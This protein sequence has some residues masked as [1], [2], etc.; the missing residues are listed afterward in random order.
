MSTALRAYRDPPVP[1][2][3][4][5]ECHECGQE[6]EWEICPMCGADVIPMLGMMGTAQVVYCESC[7]WGVIVR[8]WCVMCDS[9]CAPEAAFC[10]DECERRAA[11]EETSE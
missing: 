2:L 4:S 3:D 1:V 8:R 9:P 5:F 10:S 11:P 7:P 6:H